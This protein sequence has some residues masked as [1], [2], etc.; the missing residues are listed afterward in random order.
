MVNDEAL[1]SGAATS[2]TWIDALVRFAVLVSRAVGVKNTFWSTSFIWVAEELSSA[3]AYCNTVSVG[4]IGV[5]ATW[6][7]IAGIDFNSW[8]SWSRSWKT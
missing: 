3:L 5:G 7:R 4:A 2:R 6:R 8:W 1:G